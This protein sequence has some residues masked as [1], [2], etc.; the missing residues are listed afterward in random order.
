MTS[1]L[2]VSVTVA[3][4]AASGELLMSTDCTRSNFARASAVFD[5][6]KTSSLLSSASCCSFIVRP[7][8]STILFLFLNATTARSAVEACSRNSRSRACN[9]V[10]ARRAD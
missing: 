7:P 5:R 8:A 1:F 10:P 4:T 2:R 6:A 9:Q 3:E